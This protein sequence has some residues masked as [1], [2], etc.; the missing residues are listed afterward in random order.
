[1]D[2]SNNGSIRFNHSDKNDAAWDFYDSVVRSSDGSF[3]KL[4]VILLGMVFIL[5]QVSVIFK[6]FFLVPIITYGLLQILGNLMLSSIIWH[7]MYRDRDRTLLKHLHCL[8]F[9]FILFHNSVPFNLV[10]FRWVIGPYPEFL[11][12]LI[13]ILMASCHFGGC[14]ATVEIVILRQ[15]FF[16]FSLL[17][18]QNY[19]KNICKN[20]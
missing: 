18:R 13:G 4:S 8:L 20:I 15:V 5:T 12:G 2:P 11:C 3:H 17:I 14:I 16:L 10:I 9:S 19:L 7:E 6:L 1:M